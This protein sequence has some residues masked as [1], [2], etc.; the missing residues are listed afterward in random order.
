MLVPR[1]AG[2]D[3]LRCQT[4]TTQPPPLKQ[5][6]KVGDSLAPNL[7]KQKVVLSSTIPIKNPHISSWKRNRQW[8]CG[9]FREK[10][11]INLDGEHYGGKKRKQQLATTTALKKKEGGRHQ[12]GPPVFD[13]GKCQ[14]DGGLSLRKNYSPAHES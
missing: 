5:K 4:K 13:D 9:F 11:K 1:R 3:G 8:R 6:G 14:E 7:Q 12:G 2:R 10:K